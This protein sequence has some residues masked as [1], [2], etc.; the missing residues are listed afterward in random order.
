MADIYHQTVK[1]IYSYPQLNNFISVRNYMYIWQN[2]KKC[3]ILRFFNGFTQEI[4]ELEYTVTQIDIKGNVIKQ[5]D[6]VKKDICIS[7]GNLY[8]P[9]T[10]LLV[11]DACVDFRLSVKSARSGKYTYRVFDD[12]I[13]AFYELPEKEFFEDVKIS[14]RGKEVRDFS[15]ESRVIGKPKRAGFIAVVAL[16]LILSLNAFQLAYPYIDFSFIEEWFDFEK[17]DQEDETNEVDFS[18]TLS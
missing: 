10:G 17:Q 11:D 16:I 7:P 6:V 1:G 12:V 4:N 2:G 5:S 9:N 13:E 3:L 14:D 18:R 15:E 8:S